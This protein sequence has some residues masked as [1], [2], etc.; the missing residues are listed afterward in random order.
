MPVVRYRT[1]K[2]KAGNN[3]W[4]SEKQKMEVVASY[5]LL[6]NISQVARF[7][8]VPEIT[9]R[10][11]KASPWWDEAEAECKRSTKLELSGKL[12]KAIDLA[13]L[14]IEDRLTHGDWSFN[15]KTGE[16]VRKPVSTDVA[17]KAFD[18]LVDKQLLLEKAADSAVVVTE[19]GINERLK[20][21][22]AELLK[23]APSS[24]QAQPNI[25]DL[26]PIT[27]EEL[28]EEAQGILSLP[29]GEEVEQRDEDGS[30]D[31]GRSPGSEAGGG[32][33]FGDSGSE[34]L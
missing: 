29:A 15:P 24:S 19:E 27:D 31:A 7:S 17:I 18:K 13:H 14:T 12:R 6:G 9:I 33:L 21:I 4:W 28:S 1:D 2:K 8:G 22:A 16:M 5:L 11:W 34:R 25:I 32:S 10:K 26:E 23:F 3:G 30:S 20:K